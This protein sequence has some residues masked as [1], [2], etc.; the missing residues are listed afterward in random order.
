MYLRES[1]FSFYF[2][3]YCC[4]TLKPVYPQSILNSLD[5]FTNWYIVLF[6][7]LESENKC[8]LII[9]FSFSSDTMQSPLSLGVIFGIRVA[10]VVTDI[11]FTENPNKLLL[12]GYSLC[13]HWCFQRFNCSRRLGLNLGNWNCHYNPTVAKSV[14][15]L[16][17][18]N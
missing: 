11:Y 17:L 18:H 1:I 14:L 15:L 12:F 7:C 5:S 4:M 16:A 9:I 8:Y 10:R 2:L 13:C 6:H 3:Y